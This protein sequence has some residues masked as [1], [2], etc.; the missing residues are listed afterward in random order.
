VAEQVLWVDGVQASGQDMRRGQGASMAPS[1]AALG[2]RSGVRPGPDLEVTANSTPNMSVNVAP[3]QAHAQL[4]A[5]G[6][7]LAILTNDVTRNL[8]IAA[9]NA[10][11]PRRDLIVF[12]V[13]DET[14]AVGSRRGVLEVVTGVPAVSPADPAVPANSV[15]LARV[16]VAANAASIGNANITD[17][18]PWTTALGGITPSRDATDVAGAFVGQYRDRLDTGA[19][20]RWNGTGWERVSAVRALT[21]LAIRHRTTSAGPVSAQTSLDWGAGEINVPFTVPAS[22]GNR[23]VE[24]A[25]STHFVLTATTAVGAVR[26]FL[27][28]TQ[29]RAVGVSAAV[30][31]N[32][33]ALYVSRM[34]PAAPGAHTARVT[35]ESTGGNITFDAIASNPIELTV[36]DRG[37]V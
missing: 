22:P 19:L 29:V 34:A 27:D 7:G 36:I 17:L 9:A 11:N 33:T 10:T 26:L 14:V 24:I 25:L 16:A 4:S 3:G 8:P 37:P 28:G 13:Y 35:L 6:S 18:R 15:V 21:P 12:R 20:E 5:F 30:A 32:G 2:S 31:N 1:G 23:W